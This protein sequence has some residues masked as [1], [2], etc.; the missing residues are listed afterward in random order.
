MNIYHKRLLDSESIIL[1]NLMNSKVEKG[2]GKK[3]NSRDISIQEDNPPYH[4]RGVSESSLRASESDRNIKQMLAD[5]VSRLERI[6]EKI[7]EN[8]YPTES[9]FKPEFVG[10]VKKART[11]IKKG[12]GKSYDTID[13][14]FK[15]ID[16]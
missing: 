11:E 13:D 3:Q 14:F 16:A 8:V 9:A 1:D 2:P 5:I 15:E 6:E 4:T 10:Q 12:K 7:D